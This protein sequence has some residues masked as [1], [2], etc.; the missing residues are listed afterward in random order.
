L[1]SVDSLITGGSGF[2]GRHLC[3]RLVDEGQCVHAT[4]RRARAD[5]PSGPIWH[6]AD[7]ADLAAARR[8]FAALKP[9]VVYHLAGAVGASTDLA[10]AVPTFQSLL[11]STI[12]VLV[13]ATEAG[14]RRIVLTGSLTE[15]AARGGV[16]TPQSPYAAAKWAASGYG[17]MFHS[18]YG[19]PV[20]IL[21]PFMAYGPGQAPTKLVPSVT[22]SLLRGERPRLS[23]GSTRADWVYIGDVIEG[24][25]AAATAPGIEGKTI[26]LGTGR[27]TRMRDLIARLVTFA[28]TNI[29]PEFGA[30]PDRPNENANAANTCLAAEALGWRAT[31]SLDLGLEQTVGWYRAKVKEPVPADLCHAAP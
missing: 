30:L 14:C 26:D 23:S 16:A 9:D 11:A 8:L 3:R 2:I 25:A 15:P 17:R 29:E 22:L 10:L 1:A 19:A 4:T 28:G 31:T 27:L 12:N 21:R 5:R 18:L 6:E 20:V 13:A 7:M 24:F